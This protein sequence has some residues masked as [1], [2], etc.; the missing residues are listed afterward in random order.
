MAGK[1]KKLSGSSRHMELEPNWQSFF[2]LTKQIVREEMPESGRQFSVLEMLAYGQRLDAAKTLEDEP[3]TGEMDYAASKQEEKFAALER[4]ALEEI[5]KLSDDKDPVL[6]KLSKVA[7][8][9]ADSCPV[10][11]SAKEGK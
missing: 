4:K 7:K 3:Y 10:S 2:E 8:E 1:N 6:D 5:Q 9:F 11:T